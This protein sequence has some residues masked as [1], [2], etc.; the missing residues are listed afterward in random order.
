MPTVASKYSVEQKGEKEKKS[1]PRAK[2]K[3]NSEI[4]PEP[5][6]HNPSKNKAK[7]LLQLFGPDNIGRQLVDQL[8]LELFE[9]FGEQQ[10]PSPEA[11][12]HIREFYRSHKELSQPIQELVQSFKPA[13]PIHFENVP[14][15]F[16]LGRQRSVGPAITC[17]V[18]LLSYSSF[19][20]YDVLQ[21]TPEVL[22]VSLDQQHV[23]TSWVPTASNVMPDARWET[24]IGIEAI[25]TR[26]DIL[27][28]LDNTVTQVYKMVEENYDIVLEQTSV[29]HV[30]TVGIVTGC[31]GVFHREGVARARTNSR[32]FRRIG[33]FDKTV[34]PSRGD[35]VT[36]KVNGEALFINTKV[37]GNYAV[38]RIGNKWKFESDKEV[39]LLVEC[40]PSTA[41]PERVFL[42]HAWRFG[43]VNNVG[44]KFGEEL[45]KRKKITIT[46][47]GKA[48][49]LEFPSFNAEL[50][51][52]RDGYVLHKGRQQYFLKDVDTIDVWSDDTKRKLEELYGDRLVVEWSE[53]KA[54]YEVHWRDDKLH[55]QFKKVRRDKHVENDFFNIQEVINAPPIESFLVILE[56]KK[57]EFL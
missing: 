11:L 30:D 8:F 55:L 37:A 28:C 14:E 54:E 5:L 42:I 51:V 24:V 17:L 44:V 23:V 48:M 39:R 47:D 16:P 18:D 34:M 29:V 20:S 6:E 25:E 22:D 15:L 7:L 56:E 12:L 27:V 40:V 26:D 1:V 50:E 32:E 3:G 33:T 35:A 52:P 41:H 10:T 19:C 46:M 38:D 2:S 13:N 36:P 9:K 57:I 53:H 43:V 21:Q 45:L 49:N 31:D 4:N